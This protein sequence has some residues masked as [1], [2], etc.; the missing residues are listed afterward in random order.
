MEQKKVTEHQALTRLQSELKL[1]DND[2]RRAERLFA[3]MK[4]AQAC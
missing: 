2:V 4:E 1:T 3:A